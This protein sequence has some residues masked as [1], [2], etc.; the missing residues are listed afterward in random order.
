MLLKLTIKI[1]MLYIEI[2][3]YT[4]TSLHFVL[5]L[6]ATRDRG[7]LFPQVYS[8]VSIDDVYFILERFKLAPKFY[9]TKSSNR[10]VSYGFILQSVA[11]CCIESQV[12]EILEAKKMCLISFW[13]RL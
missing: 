11:L 7:A 3:M 6:G 10:C 4:L 13:Q 12:L 9:C 8:H 1:L 5:G 2:K